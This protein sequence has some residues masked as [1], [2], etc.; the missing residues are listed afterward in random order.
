MTIIEGYIQ[1]IPVI[2]SAIGGIPEI[3]QNGQ[4]GYTFTCRDKNDL[5]AKIKKASYLSDKE[6]MEMSLSAR[7]FA[8]NNF[9][10]GKYYNK[11]IDFYMQII[12]N[13]KKAN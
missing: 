11:L 13:I 12:N 6:Y 2:G 9:N 4:T 1:G 10:E 5:I 7:Q 3:I 8:E